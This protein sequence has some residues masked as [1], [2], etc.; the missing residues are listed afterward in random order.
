LLSAGIDVAR[1]GHAGHAFHVSGDEYAHVQA[2]RF[3]AGS[4]GG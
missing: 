4:F 2:S 3:T 1:P